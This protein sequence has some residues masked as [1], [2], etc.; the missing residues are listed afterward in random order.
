MQGQGH[1]LS[2]T[3]CTGMRDV[4]GFVT[5]RVTLPVGGLVAFAG[6]VTLARAE[7]SALQRRAGP[8]TPMVWPPSKVSVMFAAGITVTFTICMHANKLTGL[9]MLHQM[10]T[11]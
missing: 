6:P 5:A 9:G 7:S 3:R 1:T 4:L 8:M 11:K 2:M 10:C